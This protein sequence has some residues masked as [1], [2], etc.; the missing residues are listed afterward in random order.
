MLIGVDLLAVGAG[1]TP[2]DRGARDLLVE[3]LT[4]ERGHGFRIADPGNVAVGIED[5]R[6]RDDRPGQAAAA[7]LVHARDALKPIRRMV[8]SRVRN[9][10]TFTI[11]APRPDTTRSD[12]F[13]F[14]HPRRLAL[15]LAEEVEL[16][17]AHARRAD[18]V[19]LV[20]DRRVQREDA[21][22]A[23]PERHLAHRERRARAAPVH[24]DHH[25]LEYLDSFLVALANLDMDLDG[26]AWLDRRALRPCCRARRS[27]PH[28]SQRSF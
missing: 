15:Q 11:E 26:I 14:L 19:D 8:F 6:R 24:A 12:F 7:D 20:D 17:A 16:G 25:A 21:L 10:R 4:L 3:L 13:C 22:D 1:D 23:L 5:H 9:A 2:R 27:Q 28:S 18:D